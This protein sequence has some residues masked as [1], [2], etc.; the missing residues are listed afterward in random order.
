[1]QRQLKVLDASQSNDIIQVSLWWE[2]ADSV[3]PNKQ[4][5][6]TYIRNKK[7]AKKRNSNVKGKNKVGVPNRA[8]EEEKEETLLKIPAKIKE[9]NIILGVWSDKFKAGSHGPVNQ[10]LSASCP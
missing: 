3:N 6:K 10:K 7:T 5:K 8:E 1:M 4:K 2:S 9:L